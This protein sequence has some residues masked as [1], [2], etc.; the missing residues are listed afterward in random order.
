MCGR[1]IVYRFPIHDCRPLPGFTPMIQLTS[2]ENKATQRSVKASIDL[3]R[4]YVKL[5][6]EHDGSP[7]VMRRKQT[8]L[9][10]LIPL[11][12]SVLVKLRA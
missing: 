10:K 8:R 4:G 2:E 7:T 1:L 6:P 12:E 5:N 11:L 9:R 3:Y